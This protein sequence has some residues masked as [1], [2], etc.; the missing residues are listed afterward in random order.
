MLLKATATYWN[1]RIFVG[2]STIDVLHSGAELVPE[3]PTA[4]LVSAKILVKPQDSSTLEMVH[5]TSRNE[6]LQN[7]TSIERKAQQ[8]DDASS[9]N[10]LR[11]L[12]TSSCMT[13]AKLNT[14]A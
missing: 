13:T 7:I 14:S 10:A 3:F 1:C 11:R 5:A 9:E 6:E 8:N 2:V 4:F 12:L